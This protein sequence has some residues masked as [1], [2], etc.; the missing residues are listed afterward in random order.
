MSV[1]YT[2]VIKKIYL[3]ASLFAFIQ[4]YVQETMYKMRKDNFQAIK[5]S[6]RE[7]A[8]HFE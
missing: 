2:F 7:R 8:C 1:S 5:E 4:C 6:K 3:N